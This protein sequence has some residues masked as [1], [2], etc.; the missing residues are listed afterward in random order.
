MRVWPGNQFRIYTA[1]SRFDLAFRGVPPLAVPSIPGATHGPG[2]N[3]GEVSFSITGEPTSAGDGDIPGD[4]L[5]AIMGYASRIAGVLASHDTTSLPITRV[6]GGHAEG[7]PVLVEWWAIGSNERAGAIGTAIV[8]PAA[9]P[10]V[11]SVPGAEVGPGDQPGEVMASIVAP[12]SSFGDALVQG[13]GLGVITNYVTRI[14]G[15]EVTHDTTTLPIVRTTGGHA[16]GV[17]VP[18]EWWA[19]GSGGRAGLAGS[20][21]VYPAV[22]PPEVEEIIGLVEQGSGFGL[23]D[24]ASGRGLVLFPTSAP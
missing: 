13:D 2:A 11:P 19:L 24:R 9:S 14:A 17:E 23:V 6:S 20:A 1:R 5:G 8:I 10:I 22:T 7:F 4:R 16:E 12:P 3:P 18:V 21:L 15:V